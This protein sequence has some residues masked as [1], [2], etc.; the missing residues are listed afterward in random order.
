MD[1]IDCSYVDIPCVK[2]R[3]SVSGSGIGAVGTSH[4]SRY[5][6]HILGIKQHTDRNSASGERSD[7]GRWLMTDN[8]NDLGKILQQ[9]RLM[10]PLTLQEL[11]AKSGVSVAHLGRIERGDRFPSAQVLRKIAKPL[12]FDE[13]QLFIRAGFLS[14]SPPVAES[15]GA[16]IRQLDTY[17]A[18]LLSQSRWRY[19]APSLKSSPS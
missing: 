7:T 13:T 5:G 17:V 2:N 18:T 11:A 16:H 12:G 8:G 1:K 14:P 9:R 6:V 19:S 4:N 10:I 3:Y 15:E